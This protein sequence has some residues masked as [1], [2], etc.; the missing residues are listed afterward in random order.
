MNDGTII[1]SRLSTAYGRLKDLNVSFF[2][3]MLAEMHSNSVSLHANGAS[4]TIL[5]RFR[6]MTLS[7][8]LT[9]IR[10]TF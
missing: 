10:G 2:T 8:S 7:V 5:I 9:I 6:S 3:I 1:S 4:S